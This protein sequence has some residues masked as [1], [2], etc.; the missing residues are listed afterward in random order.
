IPLALI[1][2]AQASL[3]GAL[4]LLNAY[5]AARQTDASTFSGAGREEPANAAC[6]CYALL[7]MSL[8]PTTVFFRMA[9]SESLLLVVTIGAMYAMERR[10]HPF[11]VSLVVGFATA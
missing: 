1:I 2:V 4:P 9:Y 11:W 6:G 10:W 7:A 5:I 3:L 8:W